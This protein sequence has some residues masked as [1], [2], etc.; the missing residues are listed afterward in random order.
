MIKKVRFSLIISILFTTVSFSDEVVKW[1]LDDLSTATSSTDSINGLIA[2]E[3]GNVVFGQPGATS[4]TGNSAQFNGSSTLQVPYTPVLNP[5]GS[6]SISAWVKPTDGGG[7]LR[8]IISSRSS[9]NNGF[10]IRISAR[11]TIHFFVGDGSWQYVETPVVNLNQWYHILATFESLSVQS[12]VHTGIAK[13]Y[14]DG[15]LYQSK[16]L[17]Y[18]PNTSSVRPFRIGGG[19]DRDQDMDSVFNFIG[20]VDE[21]RIFDTAISPLQELAEH[22][23]NTGAVT[24][25]V[26]NDVVGDNLYPFINH[27]DYPVNAD[28]EDIL[29]GSFQSPQNTGSN[30]GAIIEAYYTPSLSG[31]YMFKFS[32]DDHGELHI[33]TDQNP[34]NLQKIA[35]VHGWS[36]FNDFDKFSSQTSNE[37]NLIAGQ[38]Y[39]LRGIWSEGGGG[40]HLNVE[41]KINGGVQQQI[42]PSELRPV[43]LDVETNKNIL[44]E[45]IIQA[46]LLFAAAL[47]NIGTVEGT[48]SP[49]SIA[50]FQYDL[51]TAQAVYA[52]LAS[53]GRELYAANW[54]LSQKVKG[55]V[56]LGPEN[57]KGEAFGST[58][59]MFLEREFNKA[60]DGNIFTYVDTVD[61]PGYTGL[62]L[63]QAAAVKEIQF[64]PVERK[65]YRLK[66]AKFQGSIDGI[67]WIDLH[68]VPSE[69]VYDWNTVNLSSNTNAY[70]YYRLADAVHT[71]VAEINFKAVPVPG[72]AVVKDMSQSLVYDLADQAISSDSLLLDNHNL[73]HHLITF[74]IT[75]LPQNGILK[76]NGS[77]FT[78]DPQNPGTFL[79]AFTQQE[80]DQGLLTFSPDASHNNDSFVFDA[81]DVTGE[82]IL[83]ITFSLIID[84]DQDGIDDSTEIADNITAW[85][86]ADSDGDG[87]T[88]SWE[89]DNGTDPAS[90]TQAAAVTAIEGE[91]GIMA[92]YW[93]DT[94]SQVA[95][96]NF[97]RY[98]HRVKKLSQ[99]NF[100]GSFSKN[101]GGSGERTNVVAKFETLLWIP[102]AGTYSFELTSD[103]GSRLFIDNTLVISN[104]G[105]HAPRKKTATKTFITEGFKKIKLEYLQLGALHACQL[106]WSGPGQEL[107]PIPAKYFFISKPELDDLL[108]TQDTDG[109][110]LTDIQ[111][112]TVTNTDPLKSD[113]DGDL[114][115]DGDEVIKWGTNPLKFDTDD[116]GISDYDEVMLFSSNPSFADITGFTTVST[117]N[118]ADYSNSLG[119]WYKDGTAAV[120]ASLRGYVEYEIE[121]PESGIF[122][123]E[124]EIAQNHEYPGYTKIPLVFYVN[125]VFISKSSSDIPNGQ[126]ATQSFLTPFLL[127]GTHTVKMYWD[128]FHLNTYA[129]INNLKLISIDGPDADEN[130]I[131]D[132]EDYNLNAQMTFELPV[133]ARISPT[134]IEGN[135]RFLNQISL[136]SNLYP[137]TPKRTTQNRWFANVE[138]DPE[139]PVEVKV[140]WLGGLKTQS[141]SISW[142]QTNL[143]TETEIAIPQGSSLLLNIIPNG[144]TEGTG[145]I[146]IEGNQEAVTPQTP[147]KYGFNTAGS[148]TITGDFTDN[149]GTESSAS[150]IVNV[151]PQQSEEQ[152]N[153]WLARD[154]SW[155]PTP[156]LSEEVVIDAPEIVIEQNEDGTF[157]LTRNELYD[158]INLVLRL[159]ENGPILNSIPT[160]TFALVRAVGGTLSLHSIFDDGTLL[161]YDQ[162]IAVNLP[163]GLDLRY[164]MTASGVTFE[165]GST[166]MSFTASDFS[167]LGVMRIGLLRLPSR[168]GSFCTKF[169]IKQGTTVLGTK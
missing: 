4:A 62:E 97:G 116:D 141:R 120:C 138:L 46:N 20:N 159:G 140:D 137:V 3:T 144:E 127:A 57:L 10:I 160:H 74:K 27:P 95:G 94:P 24:R 15:R 106:Y 14:L 76:I 65:T 147:L 61:N 118:G 107:Q 71:N 43:L 80:V 126:T 123:I 84:T 47:T 41:V 17:K 33:S 103:D 64:Y 139:T 114:L 122:K 108:L 70:S 104:D 48:F 19:G 148:F 169:E 119:Y 26:F 168:T 42:A 117:V 154:R 1:D 113:T 9:E 83:D 18:K 85:D 6:F 131:K 155:T 93:F 125:D 37:V 89:I 28:K 88:D 163:E 13:I 92:S 100:E 56:A 55:F 30:Y 167:E 5:A 124:T 59:S 86:N 36:G 96:Y 12:G 149:L 101:A 2:N 69:P 87:E 150:L 72:L 109:D 121:I 11:N 165:D 51:D 161:A 68:T 79:P 102:K 32:S 115:S 136:T 67:N 50:N 58:P 78:E 111:E 34:L 81:S 146:T 66:N 63:S 53:T 54:S 105:I 49:A 152:I 52:D 166:S 31:A 112:E 82:S 90:N 98:P 40:D 130:G 129:Q 8:S 145:T 99:I 157:T 153:I 29:T 134:C 25:K 91:N 158:E 16:T 132:W 44:N 22:F 73:Y 35:H 133:D 142:L 39:L 21:V 38:T 162:L 7:T 143:A 164:Y 151:I 60:F 135:T 75:S 156:A 77:E 110:S 128:N 45:T 23:N